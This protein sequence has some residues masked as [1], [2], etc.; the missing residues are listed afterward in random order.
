LAI[1]PEAVEAPAGSDGPWVLLLIND[2]EQRAAV[3][4]AWE[5]AG[6]AVEVAATVKDALDCLKVMTP[7]LVVIDDRLYRPVPR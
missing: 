1:T 5:D 4:R 3:R 2:D 6:F 7:S